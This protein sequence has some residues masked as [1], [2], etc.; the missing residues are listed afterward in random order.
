MNDEALLSAPGTKAGNLQRAC[1]ELLRQHERDGALPTNGRFLFYELE[2]MGVVPK[3]NEGMKRTPSQ[4]VSEATMRLRQEGLVPWEW[5]LDESRELTEPG[6]Q[7]SVYEY[8]LERARYARIDA[9]AGT[10][11]R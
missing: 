3:H 11:P 7:R 6:F 5:I 1:L 8:V 4:D 2:Q 9:W 10:S